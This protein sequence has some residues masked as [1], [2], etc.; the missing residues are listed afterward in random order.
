MG[1]PDVQITPSDAFARLAARQEATGADLVLGLV[2]PQRPATTDMVEL[3]GEE[4]V[5]R[6]EVR[7]VSTAL[8]WCW[9]VAA[10]GPRFTEH[11]HAQ[12]AA[13]PPAGPELQI[14]AVVA[15]ALAAG[16]DVWGLPLPG[17]S[18]RDVGTPADLRA[19]WRD[20]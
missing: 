19:V 5:V 14:G 4:R 13:S 15:A 18:Y 3:D 8:R 10:W 9:I 6:V 16:L 20:V 1:F 11:L 12:V 7:P 2:A 17:G